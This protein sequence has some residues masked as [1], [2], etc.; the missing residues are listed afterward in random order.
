MRVDP[1]RVSKHNP[2]QRGLNDLFPA[3]MGVYHPL[4]F[5][6]S[7]PQHNFF[8]ITKKETS[9]EILIKDSG[10][11]LFGLQTPLQTESAKSTL[12]SLGARSAP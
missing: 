3:I 7:W 6:G 2:S 10:L 5:I 9:C 1:D 8:L 11:V 4:R 12:Y